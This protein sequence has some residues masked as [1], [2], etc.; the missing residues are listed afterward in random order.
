MNSCDL[1]F[2]SGSF[3]FFLKL[4]NAAFTVTFKSSDFVKKSLIQ[5]AIDF[6]LFNA[7][8]PFTTTTTSFLSAHAAC[9]DCSLDIEA[10]FCRVSFLLGGDILTRSNQYSDGILFLSRHLITR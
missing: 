7:A 4:F 8:P 9:R 6:T 5:C 1:F 3:E 2:V 10:S